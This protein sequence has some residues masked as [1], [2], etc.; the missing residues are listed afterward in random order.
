MSLAV[1]HSMGTNTIPGRTD[2]VCMLQEDGR[3]LAVLKRHN[4]LHLGSSLQLCNILCRN[5]S[6]Q[7]WL[8]SYRRQHTIPN[9]DLKDT[10]PSL[11]LDWQSRCCAGSGE[12]K[13][14]KQGNDLPAWNWRV[15]PLISPGKGAYLQP[16][17]DYKI[18]SARASCY[19]LGCD[20]YTHLTTWSI[21]GWH[22]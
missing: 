21:K 11:I 17:S 20:S 7:C 18:R 9:L 14:R 16:F 8:A 12:L 19:F 2:L 6:P 13:V 1:T 3:S 15:K 4:I 10:A 22:D 5:A